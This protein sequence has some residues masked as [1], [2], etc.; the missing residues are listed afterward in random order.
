MG[1]LRRLGA[2]L[3]GSFFGYFFSTF[4]I[5]TAKKGIIIYS[6]YPRYNIL[7]AL[8]SGHFLDWILW[9]FKTY[10]FELTLFFTL[11]G[12][13]IALCLAK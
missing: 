10:S 1:N 2:L 11:F 6:E 8:A 12:G 4:M 13:L 7:T 3:L 9:N 5:E